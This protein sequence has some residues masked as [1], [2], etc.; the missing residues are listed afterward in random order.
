MRAGETVANRYDVITELGRGGM[1][2]VVLA[3]DRR[4]NTEV[5]IKRIPSELADDPALRSALTQEAQILARLSH[6]NI[7]RLFD[8]A[9]SPEGMFMVLEY[10]CGPSLAEFL[11]ARPRLTQFETTHLLR[12]V[13][14]GL[15]A[16]HAQRVIHRD[17]KPG[18]I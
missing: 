18:N 16:A 17:L 11:R 6:P 10:V 12:Q 4:L 14:E 15:S 2:A 5:A 8:L 3:F 13:C 1:G 7:V 9:D